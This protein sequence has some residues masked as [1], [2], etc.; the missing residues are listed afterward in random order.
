MIED[1]DAIVSLEAYRLAKVPPHAKC[2]HERSVIDE[3]S[4]TLECRE[5]GAYLSAFHVLVQ[6][7]REE[8]RAWERVKSLRAE[9]EEL[10][11][12]RPF[13]KAMKALERVWRG[14]RVLPC[15]PHCHRGLWAEEFGA[16]AVGVRHEIER[17]KA[18][19]IAVPASVDLT[20]GLAVIEPEG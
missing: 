7:A 2:K 4:G 14:R 13:L 20:G 9:A 10:K 18:L 5:C 1:D 19:G 3:R 12:W 11:A 15:C 16:S 8:N 17:R 6:I